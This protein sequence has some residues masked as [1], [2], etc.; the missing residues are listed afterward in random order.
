MSKQTVAVSVLHTFLHKSIM[1]NFYFDK[2]GKKREIQNTPHKMTDDYK[3]RKGLLTSGFFII[4]AT[5][6]GDVP[7]CMYPFLNDFMM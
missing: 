1:N 7:K 4:R 5:S 2:T 6:V 3:R